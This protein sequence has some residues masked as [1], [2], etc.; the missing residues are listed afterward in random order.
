MACEPRQTLKCVHGQMAMSNSFA[1]AHEKN[2]ILRSS[3]TGKGKSLAA[4]SHIIM[5]G[6]SMVKDSRPPDPHT[7]K[8]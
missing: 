8:K 1:P 2:P 4:A 5:C 6:H 7:D 3:D